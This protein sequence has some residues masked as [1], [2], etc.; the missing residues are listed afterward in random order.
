MRQPM[1]HRSR[2]RLGDLPKRCNENFITNKNRKY[3]PFDA[4]PAYNRQRQE[5]VRRALEALCALQ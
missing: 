1:R 3:V 5:A 2:S 4:A